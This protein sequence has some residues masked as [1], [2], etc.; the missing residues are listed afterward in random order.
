M[1]VLV[2][3]DGYSGGPGPRGF[4]GPPGHPGS[5]GTKLLSV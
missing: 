3:K 4:Q 1:T 5:D 2:G